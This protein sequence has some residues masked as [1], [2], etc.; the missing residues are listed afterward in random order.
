MTWRL[1]KHRDNVTFIT[2][3]TDSKKIKNVINVDQGKFFHNYKSNMDFN[4]KE[5]T[6]R[7]LNCSTVSQLVTER[8]VSLDSAKTKKQI[9]QKR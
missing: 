1:I 6:E 7:K 8:G 4:Q 2:K 5:N 9:G 3:M